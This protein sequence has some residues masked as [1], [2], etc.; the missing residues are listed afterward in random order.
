MNAADRSG[1]TPLGAAAHYRRIDVLNLLLKHGALVNSRST[2]GATALQ[3]ATH[4]PDNNAVIELLIAGSADVTAM[5]KYRNTP[6]RNAAFLGNREVV[7]LLVAKG[8]DVSTKDEDEGNTPL[9]LAAGNGYKEIV[10]LLL[11]K[12]A[13]VSALDKRRL[14]PLAYALMKKDN[15]MAELLRQHGGR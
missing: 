6:L 14:T 15:A 10:E 4:E 7:E 12:G 5:D 13:D 8:A 9:H 11:A 2:S 1:F 3:M